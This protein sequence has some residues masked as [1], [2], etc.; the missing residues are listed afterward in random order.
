MRLN[1]CGY[2]GLSTR[3]GHTMRAG[4]RRCRSC[5]QPAS[6]VQY[7]AMP[8]SPARVSKIKPKTSYTTNGNRLNRPESG[9]AIF[10]SG[11]PAA[12]Q[13]R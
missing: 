5:F 10:P 11:D 3:S 7:C 1:A 2:A 13:Y 6:Y 12:E 8:T 4:D 9:C